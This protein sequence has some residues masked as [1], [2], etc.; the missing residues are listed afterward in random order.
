MRTT[1]W[2]GLFVI[3]GAFACAE[4]GSNPSGNAASVGTSGGAGAP[5]AGA[6][7]SGP[8]GSGPTGAGGA[9]GAMSFDASSGASEGGSSVPDA[10]GPAEG[11][12]V[13][14]GIEDGGRPDGDAAREAATVDAGPALDFRFDGTISRAVLEN[15]LSRSISFTELLHDDLTQPAQRARRRSARQHPP[16]DRY[17]G[18]VRRTRADVV[19]DRKQPRRVLAAGEAVCRPAPSG[20]SRDHAAGGRFRNR[21]DA[22][23]E[24]CDSASGCS[25][26]SVSR[27]SR[28]TSSTRT[29]STPTATR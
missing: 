22:R 17:Q 21:H 20:R 15:Y 5:Q 6:G 1:S 11:G 18:E 4:P 14:A 27:S 19:G 13:D 25:S 24:G 23:R 8:A 12:G 7:T 10:N 2:L 28:A 3:W 9:G 29:C 16:A 26:N